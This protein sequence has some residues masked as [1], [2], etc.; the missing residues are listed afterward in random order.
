M[1]PN[2]TEAE[3][4]EWDDLKRDT[5]YYD[6]KL[7]VFQSG[8]GEIS[9]MP[10]VWNGRQDMSLEGH[11]VPLSIDEAEFLAGQLLKCVARRKAALRLA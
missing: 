4:A 5:N 6:R 7:V 10:A 11:I 1:Q 2:W 3:K 9:I 8:G